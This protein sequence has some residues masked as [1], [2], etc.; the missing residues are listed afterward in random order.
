MGPRGGDEV[1]L[2]LPGRNYGWPLYSKGI[3]Y[4]G[5]EVN[6]GQ[7]LGIE[8]DLA[9]IEQPVVD[10]TPAPAVSSFI[11]YDGEAF[12]GWQHNPLVGTLKATE[13]YRMV[14]D[15]DR[16]VHRETVLGGVGRIRDIEAAA[17]GTILLLIEH[18]EGGRILRI[19]PVPG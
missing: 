10:L 17:N 15:G 6:H 13:L 8:R 12:P 2:L 9:S 3:N 16:V 11:V 7:L 1:N 18:K 14:L 4:D 19:V 5:T